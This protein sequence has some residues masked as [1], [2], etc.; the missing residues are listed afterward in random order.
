MIEISDNEL[1]LRAA[2]LYYDDGKTQDE[3]GDIL[4][5]TRWKAGRLLALARESGIVAISKLLSVLCRQ[6]TRTANLFTQGIHNENGPPHSTEKEGNKPFL[7][8]GS[9][10][11]SQRARCRRDPFEAYY[12]C[13]RNFWAKLSSYCLLFV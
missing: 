5:I 1:A 11:N 3:I 8:R 9:G 13:W 6:Q 12:G 10:S 4:G 2:R 7:Y